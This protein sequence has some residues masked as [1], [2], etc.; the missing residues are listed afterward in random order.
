MAVTVLTIEIDSTNHVHKT[1]HSQ[2]DATC[3]EVGYTAGIYCNDCKTWIEGHEE[4]EALKHNMGEWYYTTKPTCTATGEEKRDCSRCDHFETRTADKLEHSYSDKF[5]VDKNATCTADGSKS[6]HCIN[7]DAKTDITVIKASG[8][9]YAETIINPAT[10]TDDG[11]VM[12]EC[13]CGESYT[14]GI[15]AHGHS[16]ANGDGYCDYCDE[17]L[18]GDK[19]CSCNCHKT[20]LMSIIWKILRFF[21]KLFKINP[22]CECGISHY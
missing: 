11:L 12:Y 9:K 3:T 22:V 13:S 1:E 19:D 6:R 8:H 4:I 17:N 10:C 2:V 5:T 15:P 18:T 14:E 16:D 21:Y 20:G 7:C